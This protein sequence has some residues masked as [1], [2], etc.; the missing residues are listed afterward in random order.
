MIIAKGI[1]LIE[2]DDPLLENNTVSRSM[3]KV[4]I[5]G[6]LTIT[7]RRVVIPINLSS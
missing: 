2:L 1:T 3:E 4:V 7:R 5:L 6:F